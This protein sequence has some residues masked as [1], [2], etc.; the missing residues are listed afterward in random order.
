MLG[1][2]LGLVCY[3]AFSAAVVSI[4][5]VELIPIKT[6]SDL[7]DSSLQFYADDASSTM[8]YIVDVNK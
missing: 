3:G 1:Y 4:L 6:R 2:I 7:L 5:A 8:A